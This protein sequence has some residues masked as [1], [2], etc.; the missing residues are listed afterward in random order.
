MERDLRRLINVKDLAKFEIF[1]KLYAGRTGQI[2]NLSSLGN[3]CGINHN[4][5]KAW[6]SVLEASFIIKLLKPFYKN[7]T[8]V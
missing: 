5:A 6:I 4:T 1:L 8:N 3:A 2:L 7:L